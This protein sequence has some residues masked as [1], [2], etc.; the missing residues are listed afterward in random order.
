MFARSDDRNTP[1]LV[2][3]A[4]LAD[5]ADSIEWLKK[6]LEVAR[7]VV[8]TDREEA[9][10][11]DE[12]ETPDEP[13]S[14]LPEQRM[15]ALTQIF[16][17]YKPDATPDIIERVVTRIDAVVEQVKYPSWQTSRE[18]ARLV[19]T[20]IRTALK[21]FGLPPTGDLFECAYDYVAEHY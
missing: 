5:A 9:G 1:D 18:G 21:D 13:E 17:E 14:L 20:E 2:C 4:Q 16:N 15:G 7:D 10:E 6:L 8:A 19:K 3:E 12:V 11:G